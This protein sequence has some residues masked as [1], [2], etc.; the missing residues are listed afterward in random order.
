MIN[1]NQNFA[2]DSNNNKTFLYFVDNNIIYNTELVNYN[3]VYNVNM[4]MFFS[5]GMQ[6]I[7]IKNRENCVYN[8]IYNNNQI[9]NGIIE[10]EFLHNYSTNQEMSYELNLF[11]FFVI[12]KLSRF[13]EFYLSFMESKGIKI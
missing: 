10:N 5:N 1:I 4:H 2:L 3:Y 7:V 11:V 8:I 13:N 9:C 12:K 6:L